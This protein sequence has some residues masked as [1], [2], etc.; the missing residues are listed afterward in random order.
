MSLDNQD[1]KT[2]IHGFDLK[3]H[4]SLAKFVEAILEEKTER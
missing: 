2:D 3:K 1:A 4:T